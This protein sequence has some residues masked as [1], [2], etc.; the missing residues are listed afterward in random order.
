MKC[1][2]SVAVES[3]FGENYDATKTAVNEMD[4]PLDAKVVTKVM[5]HY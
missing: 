2:S 3:G 5:L 1:D 4:V